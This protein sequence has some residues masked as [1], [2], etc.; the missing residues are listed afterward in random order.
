MWEYEIKWIWISVEAICRENRHQFQSMQLSCSRIGENRGCH[1]WTI[2]THTHAK[3]SSHVMDVCIFT[4][5]FINQFF[6]I[7][8]NVSTT[9]VL[10]AHLRVHIS[11][12]RQWRQLTKHF[13]VRSDIPISQH[14]A[15]THWLEVLSSD[16]MNQSNRREWESEKKPAKVESRV[17]RWQAIIVNKI[18]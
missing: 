11:C 1:E 14:N 17:D 12:Q 3:P 7:N 5:W 8:K 2:H 9:D 10:L 18:V 4:N 6:N 15:C 16:R 13:A